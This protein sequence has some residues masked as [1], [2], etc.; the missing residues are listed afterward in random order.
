MKPLHF[1]DGLAHQ[2]SEV[3]SFVHYLKNQNANENHIGNRFPI[4]LIAHSNGGL[5]ARDYLTRFLT[6]PE[7]IFQLITYGTPHRGADVTSGLLR[8]DLVIP[9]LTS[10]LDLLA[11]EFLDAVRDSDGARR[12]KG[13]VSKGI[14]ISHTAMVASLRVTTLP[15]S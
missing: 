10:P 9:L 1:P 14:T 5:A 4:T 15:G 6:S 2:G 12:S 7:D 13:D 3:A 8:F 11:L